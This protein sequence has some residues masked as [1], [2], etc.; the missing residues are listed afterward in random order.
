MF[1]DYIWNCEDSVVSGNII[2]DDE[3]EWRSEAC[4]APLRGE[5]KAKLANQEKELAKWRR[6]LKETKESGESHALEELI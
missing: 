1:I 5:Q 4:I 3:T 2:Q 6:K